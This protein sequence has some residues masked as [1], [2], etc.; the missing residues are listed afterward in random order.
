MNKRIN[1]SGINVIAREYAELLDSEGFKYYSTK[2]LFD[3]MV[4]K[5]ADMLEDDN[6]RF[7]RDRFFK[8]IYHSHGN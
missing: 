4:S 2:H 3:T 6:E 1:N 5:L 7:D 8:V